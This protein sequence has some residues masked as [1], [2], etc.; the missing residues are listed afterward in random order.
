MKVCPMKFNA[1][2][3][4][5]NGSHQLAGCECELND[6]AWWDEF[7]GTCAVKTLAFLERR[8]VDIGEIK[9]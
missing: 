3:L 8:K 1:E 5:L 7:T 6:C 2:T 9:H 4:D